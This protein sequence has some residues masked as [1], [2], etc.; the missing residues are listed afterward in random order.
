[1]KT[2]IYTKSVLTVIAICLFVSTFTPYDFISKAHATEVDKISEILSKPTEVR[3]VS[4]DTSVMVDV[5][6][7]RILG[8]YPAIQHYSYTA[9][10]DKS[11]APIIFTEPIN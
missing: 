3:I 7:S 4:I 9:K 8:W 1:M 6:L 5:N 10:G 11:M 2:D